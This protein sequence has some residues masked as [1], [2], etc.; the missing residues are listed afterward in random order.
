LLAVAKALV[1]RPRRTA[2]AI[3]LTTIA[4]LLA[5]WW[6]LRWAEER[7]F[8]HAL[9]EADQSDPGWRFEDIEA[10]RAVIPDEQ[11]AALVVASVHDVL[12]K[13]GNPHIELIAIAV[14]TPENSPLSTV[15]AEKLK[16]ILDGCRSQRAEA[17]RLAQLP[18]GQ[19]SALP[20]S[21]GGA[22]TG[23]LLKALSVGHLLRGE[24]LLALHSGNDAEIPEIFHAGINTARYGADENIMGCLVYVA[25][26]EDMLDLLARVLGRTPLSPA[27]LERLQALLQREVDTPRLLDAVRG[28]RALVVR[29]LEALRAGKGEAP[30]V[31]TGG[32]ILTRWLRWLRSTS[33]VNH[34]GLVRGM[35]EIVAT[36]KSPD[37]GKLGDLEKVIAAR[38]QDAISLGRFTALFQEYLRYQAEMRAMVIAL[39]AE[40]YRLEHQ[41]W[42]LSAD[43]IVTA[44]Y[45]KSVPLDP[46]DGKPMRSRPLADGMVFYSVGPDRVDN[47]GA[48]TRRQPPPP[49]TDI[50]FRVWDV[51]SRGRP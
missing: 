32:N 20:D 17:R 49:G 24:G 43:A 40:R 31:P 15:D 28:E 39:A 46:Y 4:V 19:Y 45:L 38:T 3:A 35:N 8:R 5:V 14:R 30:P 16:Q 12:E 6:Y 7:D 27:D 2:I 21:E 36:C 29:H 48:I 10:A 51:A 47:G 44:G 37:E 25:C 50:G 34:A 42:P 1:A 13:L 9:A 11:N 18:V 26:M 33:G 23:P 22:S 41:A